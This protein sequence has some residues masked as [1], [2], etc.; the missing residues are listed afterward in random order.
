MN[1][2]ATSLTLPKALFIVERAPKN[3][4]KHELRVKLVNRESSLTHLE[5]NP[6]NERV[7]EKMAPSDEPEKIQ[8]KIKVF[9]NSPK[10]PLQK[11]LCDQVMKTNMSSRRVA[12]LL[13][14][15]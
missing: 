6:S 13:G 2:Q 7:V 9:S 11:V 12:A 8:E 10:V 5:A 4:L 15:R 3:C 1:P 14:R